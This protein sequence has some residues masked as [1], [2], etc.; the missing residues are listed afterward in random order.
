MKELRSNPKDIWDNMQKTH[1]RTFLR[2]ND[3]WNSVPGNID[4]LKMN[5]ESVINLEDDTSGFGENLI[6]ALKNIKKRNKY[7]SRR[8]GSQILA[9]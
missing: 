5:Y 7:V 9:R 4:I 8:N 3:L 2:R 1:R 6:V